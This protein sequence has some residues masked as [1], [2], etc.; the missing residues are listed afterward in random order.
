MS[1]RPC[2][3][4]CRPR[5]CPPCGAFTASPANPDRPDSRHKDSPMCRLLL[6]L[7]VFFCA[8]VAPRCQAADAYDVLI[9]GGTLYDGSGDEPRRADVG[10]RGDRVAAVG[11]LA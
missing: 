8:T 5:D 11:D 1:S 10:L 7:V 3:A 4:R 6:L 9:R 2:W